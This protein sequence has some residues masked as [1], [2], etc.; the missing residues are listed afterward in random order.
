M[1]N[2]FDNDIFFDG[3]K[4]L[5]SNDYSA[6]NIDEKP[7]LFSLIPPLAGKDVIDLGC[8]FG[9]NCAEF[10][11]SGAKSVIG[12]DCS[13]K[14]LG[15]AKQEHPEIQFIHGD[16]SEI[17]LTDESADVVC[18]SLAVHYIEDFSAL[19]K[20]IFRCLRPGGYFIFSQ[21]HPLTT[22]TKLDNWWECSADGS[23]VC[24]RLSDYSLSGHRSVH[25]MIDDVEKYHRTFSDIVNAL[26]DAGFYI[27]KML[28]PV[29]SSE[30]LKRDPSLIR[31]YHKPNFLLIKARK[32]KL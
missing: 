16:M 19:T 6:N 9:E 21:E 24:Y 11:R 10:L 28:E 13:E 27:E 22:A 17:Q 18:S 30:H 4:K 20:K 23:V 26:T 8:G 14:M 29:P 3:Y 7:A 32:I 25:W 31:N 12:I 1:I 2:V 5:R 15:I